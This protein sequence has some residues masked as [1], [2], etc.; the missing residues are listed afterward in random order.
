MLS[1]IIRIIRTDK[2]ITLVEM[3]VV[4]AISGLLMVAVYAGYLVQHKT[5]NVQHQIMDIQQDLRALVDIM[6][7][8]IRMAGC[9]PS[10]QSTAG[11]VVGGTDANSLSVTMDLNR[12]GDTG[13]ANEQAAYTRN[14]LLVAR[15]G[16]VLVEGITSMGFTYFDEDNNPINPITTGNA[17]NVRVVRINIWIRSDQRD[18]DTGEFLTRTLSRRVRCRNLGL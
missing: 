4:L 7:Q 11:I 15:N 14:G 12:D 8:D 16:D 2:G 18:P 10:M 5:S 3:I 9:D 1:E 6:E 13:D 17:G